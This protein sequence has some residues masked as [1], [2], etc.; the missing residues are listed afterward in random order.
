MPCLLTDANVPSSNVGL[1]REMGPGS[2]RTPLAHTDAS[3]DDFVEH[4]HLTRTESPGV[5]R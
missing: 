2:D 3:G 1:G 5:R 4:L